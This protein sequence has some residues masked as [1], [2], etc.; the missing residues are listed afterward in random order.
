[1]TVVA[2]HKSDLNRLAN[3]WRCCD[4]PCWTCSSSATALSSLRRIRAH[5]EN[6][7][8]D[9]VAASSVRSWRIS[10]FLSR[11]ARDDAG[12]NGV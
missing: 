1:M 7:S 3:C 11:V 4:V 10:C 5:F 6:S 8:W 12:A 2:S 9:E